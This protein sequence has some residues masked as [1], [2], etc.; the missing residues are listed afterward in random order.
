MRLPKPTFKLAALRFLMAA[1]MLAPL[2]FA[3]AQQDGDTPAVIALPDTQTASETREPATEI[4]EIIVYGDKLGRT[5]AQTNSSV[6]LATRQAIEQSSDT[7]LHDVVSQFG[8]VVTANNDREI[9]I[10]GVP[11]GGLG[12]E[13]DTISVYLDG[14]ALPSRAAAFSGPQSLWDVEQVEVLRGAQST[15]QG[16]NSL[17]GSVVMRTRDPTAY[18]DARARV[19]VF[20]RDSHDYAFAGG[21]PMADWLRVRFAV[22][23]RYDN[24]EIDNITRGED[25]AGRSR[26]RNLR[27]KISFTPFERYEALLT[28]GGSNNEFGD[29]LHD[30]TQGR[31]TATSNERYN[32][33]AEARTYGLEQRLQLGE[34]WTVEAITGY[35][36]SNSFVTTDYD[37]T[38]E[39]RGISTFDID[40]DLLSQELRAVMKLDRL[41]AVF[42]LYAS[43]ER[44][45]EHDTGEDIPVGGGVALL[46]GDVYTDDR[47]R[48]F[49][50]FAEMDYDFAERWRLTLGARLNHEKIERHIVE[51]VNLVLTAPVPGLDLPVGVPL[52]DAVIDA[53]SMAQ[54]DLVPPDYDERGDRSFTD[55]LPKLGLTWSFS[56]TSSIAL[57]YQEGYRSGGTSISYF[58]GE[59]SQFD[60]EYTRTVELASRNRGFDER[61]TLNA[62][63]FY[64]RWRDQQVT[65]GDGTS[66]YTTTENAGRSHLY[67]LE[68][69]SVVAL[70]ANLEV[71]VSVGLLDTEFDEF[72]NQDVDYQ[73]NRFPQAPKQTG[74]LGLTLKQWGWLFGQLSVQYVGEYFSDPSNDDTV[75][76]PART[77][78]NARLG[79]KLPG[80]F[81]LV[82]Y[83]RNLTD[84]ENVQDTFQQVRGDDVRTAKRYGE[85]RTV[86]AL[87]EWQLPR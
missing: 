11:Q 51:E 26:T 7:D 18:W 33:D 29:V 74:A 37:R 62:N 3:L 44:K 16:R 41:R 66:F 82:A 25:D 30:S 59:V 14:V 73:G 86:G 46:D 47:T 49:A 35:I 65:I 8:N 85:S 45:D 63:V 57:T 52:P 43:Q 71:F 31:R 32:E 56:D 34:R 28:V 67:G 22:Q 68:V 79:L 76:V 36:D 27:G 75:R 15:T 87:L 58:G 23:D 50:A 78:L 40:E 19:G 13:G 1:S 5:L 42:G 12:G 53:L 60:P 39:A 20:S 80:G 55:V 10:R 64:T 2:S 48:T 72:I 61:L 9:S 83:G 4:D 17:A 81:S 77:L 24:G 54:P 6:G 38:E 69:E 84:E 21:G 70:P